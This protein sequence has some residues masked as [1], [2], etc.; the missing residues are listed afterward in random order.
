VGGL[1]G[2]LLIGF[3]ATTGSPTGAAGLDV[4]SGL[5]YGGGL[6]QLG[7]QAEGAFA[8]LIFSFVVTY[9]IGWVLHKTMG[10]RVSE[11]DEVGGI[12]LAEHA[13]T[14][15][16][17]VS[18]GGSRTGSFLSGGHLAAPSPSSAGPRPTDAASAAN[19]EG[20]SA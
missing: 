6:S 2:T 14:G 16:D 10:F 17:L 1:I 11:D 19:K 15:Y 8:V 12:D 18:F 20:A 5:F 13:E 3:F 4:N 9:A 7:A